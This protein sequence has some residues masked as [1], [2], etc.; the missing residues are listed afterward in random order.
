MDLI[1]SLPKTKNGY[2]A[3]FVVVDR[4]T[5]MMHAIPITTN[6]NAP[7]LANIFLKEIYRLHGMP[8]IIVSDRDPRFTS[9]F[10]RSLFTQLQTKL[11]MSTAYHP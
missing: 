11:S 3:I 10:W 6:I 1:V 9:I 2:D 5:K 4:L 8:K 7:Q